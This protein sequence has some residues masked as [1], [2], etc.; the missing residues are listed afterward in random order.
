VTARV[1]VNA[2]GPWV[3]NIIEN[4]LGI[5]SSESVRLVRGS[6]IVTRKLFEHDRAYI[7]QGSDDR[8]VFAIPFEGDFTLVGTTE[9]DHA[10]LSQEAVCSP[11]EADYLRAAVSEY[12]AVPV[13]A[14]DIVWTYSGVRPLYDDG[15][16]SA[17]AATREYV[18]SL[19]APEGGPALLN[20][21]GGKITTYRR[22]AEAALAK[23][24]PHL[25]EMGAA[26][27]AGAALPGGDFPYDGVDGLIAGLREDY[28]FL[29]EAWA[30]RLVRAYGT[31]AR[32][33]LGGAERREQL[34]SQFGHDLPER[35]VVWLM[36]REW[37]QNAQ[38]VLWR[39]SKLGLWLTD[40]QVDVLDAWMAQKR[41]NGAGE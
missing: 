38:D 26:W 35:E 19:D 1:L 17:T 2:G 39:R 41:A 16:K 28:D 34:G 18:L 11:E 36:D 23:I 10:D 22:L 24:E 30:R 3:S 12:L 20:V 27:T 6:H 4:T 8:I 5:N 21:F 13:E 31:Q 25:P 32:E 37:A 29:D 40:E 15:A 33:M 14:E 7:F 9:R